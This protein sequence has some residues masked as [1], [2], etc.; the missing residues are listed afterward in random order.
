MDVARRPASDSARTLSGRLAGLDALRGIAALC[1][2]CLHVLTIFGPEHGFHGKGY[3]A[4]DFFFML[5]GYVMARTYERRLA[6]GYGTGRFVLARY[7]R[8]WPVMAVGAL[9]GAPLVAI[10]LGDPA[11]SFPVILANLFLI[12]AVAGNVIYPVN[13][14]AWSILAELSANLAHGAVLWRWH[15]PRLAMLLAALIPLIVGLAIAFGRLDLGADSSTWAFGIA[16]ALLAYMAFIVLWRCWRDRPG[17]RINPLAAFAAMPAL[18]LAVPFFG[19][20]G[21]MFDV[22]FV[23]LVCPLLVAGGLAYRGE[24][25]LW[26]W[27]GMISFP[28]YA[29]NLPLLHWSDILGLGPVTGIACALALATYIALRTA[30]RPRARCAASRRPDGPIGGEARR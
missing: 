17:I 27:L 8:L 6:E 26:R 16:R 5:S 13:G 10:E 15:L 11:R 12:P 2:L 24:H 29:I 28:L 22:G 4:V 21:R 20:G 19:I 25:G 7:R 18:L 14:A 1:V 3:L 9:I 23:L 30:P